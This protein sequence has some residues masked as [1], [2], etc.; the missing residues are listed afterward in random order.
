MVSH[1]TQSEKISFNLIA[2]CYRFVF[3]K[4]RVTSTENHLPH[5]KKLSNHISLSQWLAF[6]ISDKKWF[7]Q[8]NMK[9]KCIKFIGTPFSHFHRF[10]SIA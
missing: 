9:E 2:D 10:A 7:I 4:L 5:F 1:S 6:I 3:M 8:Q